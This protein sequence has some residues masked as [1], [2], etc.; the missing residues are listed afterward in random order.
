VG[1]FGVELKLMRML[2]ALKVH[3]VLVIGILVF[4]VQFIIPCI[5]ESLNGIHIYKLS[6]KDKLKNRH[7]QKFG[8]KRNKENATPSV[9]KLIIQRCV[10]IIVVINKLH[11]N[12]RHKLDSDDI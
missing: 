7:K 11:H 9:I 4:W 10:V 12:H 2:W 8:N 6:T 1:V 3:V 5:N